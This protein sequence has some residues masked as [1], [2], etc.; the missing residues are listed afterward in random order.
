MLNNQTLLKGKI[1]HF[2]A[3]IL[4]FIIIIGVI[5]GLG[6][7]IILHQQ[8]FINIALILAIPA[9]LAVII[10]LKAR[11]QDIDLNKPC[12]IFSFERGLLDKGFLLL[13][14]FSFI[15]A[16]IFPARNILF[17][18][19]ITILYCII[20]LQIFSERPS[21]RIILFE[22]VLLLLTVIY[23]TTLKL[24]Y[25]FGATD[26]SPHIFLATVT[27]LSGSIIPPDLSLA[28]TYFPLYHIWLASGSILLNLDIKVALFLISGLAFAISPFF[29]YYIFDRFFRNQQVALLTCLLYSVSSIVIYYGAY[30]V[31]RTMAFLG[32]LIF[33]YLLYKYGDSRSSDDQRLRLIYGSL[34]ILITIY[35]LLVHQVSTPQIILLLGTLWIC[36]WFWGKKR[37]LQNNLFPLLII[38]FIGY[39]IFV[40]YSF[41][42]TSIVPR[43]ELLSTE[44]LVFKESL[45]LSSSFLTTFI[46]YIDWGVFIFFSF[47]GVG[48]ILYKKNS[49]YAP[50]FGI[51][52]LITMILYIPSPLGLLWQTIV[53]LGFYRFYLLLSPFMAIVMGFGI[54][55]FLQY[56]ITNIQS[57][58]LISIILLLLFVVYAGSGV[59]LINYEQDASRRYWFNNEEIM[60]FEFILSHIPYGSIINSDYYI[61]RFF[62]QRHFSKSSSL[63]LP[64]YI[65]KIMPDAM[66]VSSLEGIIVIPNKQF[67]EKGMQ[68]NKNINELNPE[69][70]FYPYLPTEENIHDLFWGL[71]NKNKIYDSDVIVVYSDN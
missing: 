45:A 25:Y 58:R 51:F 2:I 9:I 52:A 65:S 66:T 23:D 69:S 60:G 34:L 68:L 62:S 38:L 59:G 1:L 41:I 42:N 40:A 64:Y 4:P 32:F 22:I 43:I 49:S 15:A 8:N 29:V 50:V 27:S 26:V 47:I 37:Y 53:V 5:I 56:F 6:I 21:R 12:I 19:L 20:L 13:F 30:V 16:L 3:L 70:G 11:E 18:S 35:I 33:I 71:K 39:W 14:I 31:S 46:N 54:L 67:T 24:P 57:K 7:A 28:N 17:L 48:F 61:A 10:L 44:T 55:I 63:D 36:E